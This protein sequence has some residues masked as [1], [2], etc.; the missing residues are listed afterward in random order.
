MK[1][2]K[3]KYKSNSL[4]LPLN[5]CLPKGGDGGGRSWSGGGDGG[6][7]RGRGGTGVEGDGVI[8]GGW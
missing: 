7:G 6:G 1:N 8:S 2:E 4:N 3:W 5:R